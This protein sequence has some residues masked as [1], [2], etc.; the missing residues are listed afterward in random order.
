MT[1]ENELA[2][3]GPKK[4]LLRKFT[5]LSTPPPPP[6]RTI[7]SHMPLGVNCQYIALNSNTFV[8][9]VC[10][11]SLDIIPMYSKHSLLQLSIV[12]F[13]HLNLPQ[14]LVKLFCCFFGG[15]WV[16]YLQTVD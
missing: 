15:I 10:P 9:S 13:T 12:G 5:L 16:M 1:L 2:V 4:I 11:I 6:P 8:L 3:R 14:V 7:C